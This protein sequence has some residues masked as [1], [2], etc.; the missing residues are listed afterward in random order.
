MPSSRALSLLLAGLPCLSPAQQHRLPPSVATP[1]SFAIVV[2]STTWTALRAPLL[3]YRDAVQADGLATWVVADD[4]RS[5]QA[6]RDVLRELYAAQPPL[7]GAILVGRIPVAM[8]RG[9]QHLTSAFKMDEERYERA[10]SSVPTDRVYEDFDLQFEPLEPDPQQPLL[11]YL[12]LAPDSAQRVDKEIY[13]A[14]L[15][16]PTDDDA[17]LQAVAAC[18]RRFAADRQ[19][20]PRLDR[21]LTMLGH[22][23]VSES[24]QAWADDGAALAELVPAARR[25]GGALLALHHDRGAPLQQILL[26]ELADPGLDLA[27]LHS[28]GDDDRQFLL[29]A[30]PLPSAAAQIAAVRKHLRQRLRRAKERGQAPEQTQRELIASLQVPEAWF[31]DAFDP[32]VIAADEAAEAPNDLLAVE[33]AAVPCGAEL[34]EL[35]ACF[36][37]AFVSRPY[38]AAAYLFGA[39]SVRAVVANS[40]NVAQDVAGGRRLGLLAQ[41]A[42]IGAWHR[43]RPHLESHLFGDPTF[44][45]A[46]TDGSPAADRQ[47]VLDALSAQPQA[48][49]R[50]LAALRDD[51]AASVRH[52]ALALL[53][54]RR[55]PDLSAALLVALQDPAEA[56]RRAAAELMGDVGSPEFVAPLLHTVLR[57]TAERVVYRAR[58]ALAKYDDDT[59]AAALPAAFAE[60]PAPS[61][62][63]LAQLRRGL[64]APTFLDEYRTTTLDRALPAAKRVAALRTFRLYRQH[65]IVPTLLGLAAAADEDEAVRA[66]A[67]EALGWFVYSPLVPALTAAMI[68]LADDAAAPAAVRAEARKTARRLRDGANDPLLP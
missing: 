14:R 42:R 30:P 25:R 4:W 47:L 52:H 6:V 9:A 16:P 37:G 10:R 11:H 31:A 40:V 20:P 66:A 29:G 48:S 18:L 59:V 24:L 39:G 13:T 62:Q 36:N 26:R 35:D 44:R 34:V 22:G 50:L 60:L 12:R 63:D 28:H 51:P 17:G 67:I 56:V 54:R 57:E 58:D 64:Q 15:L 45:F 8:V 61:G 32:A 27:I 3:A 5:P 2:D 55:G 33:V 19:S 68:R 65:A 38:Q 46:W 21:V 41:G 1:T 49:E 7:E 43:T 23:Y 53:A